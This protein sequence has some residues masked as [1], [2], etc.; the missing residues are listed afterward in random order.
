MH[1]ERRRV[2]QNMSPQ[3]RTEQQQ[4]AIAQ[5]K[6]AGNRAARKRP[7]KNKAAAAVDETSPQITLSEEKKQ[8]IMQ[9]TAQGIADLSDVSD[10]SSRPQAA[11]VWPEARPEDPLAER[12]AQAKL[13]AM[14]ELVERTRKFLA[15]FGSQAGK[16]WAERLAPGAE[17]PGPEVTAMWSDVS[18]AELVKPAPKHDLAHAAAAA[19]FAEVNKTQIA[20][21]AILE[22][23]LLQ[24]YGD[25][26]VMTEV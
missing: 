7:T 21:V 3:E 20:A 23:I 8:Q 18:Y 2:Y 9:Q 19:H 11:V 16:P 25:D 5:H 24:R 15:K 1:L 10:N 17:A 6:P 4:Q 22:T 26:F 12:G 14:D 13:A